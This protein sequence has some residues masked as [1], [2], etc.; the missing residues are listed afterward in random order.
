MDGQTIPPS[1][2]FASLRAAISRGGRPPLPP[3]TKDARPASHSEHEQW[4]GGL[5]WGG[6]TSD[7]AVGGGGRRGEDRGEEVVAK[8]K[9]A[10][11]T[12]FLC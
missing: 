10:R 1:S 6:Y 11:L 2:P 7:S 4:R 3:P 8:H 5:G 9:L 12:P